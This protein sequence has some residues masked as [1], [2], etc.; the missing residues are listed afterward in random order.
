MKNTEYKFVTIGLREG[1]SEFYLKLTSVVPKN[2]TEEQIYHKVITD[3][4]GEPE[5]VDEDGYWFRG[6]EYVMF[7]Y[8]IKPMTK[9]EFEVVNKFV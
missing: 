3:N 7:G 8:G 6:G 5:S 9:D 4:E 1:E 2:F